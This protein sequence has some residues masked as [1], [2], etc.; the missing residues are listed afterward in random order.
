MPKSTVREE[1]AYPL[2][3]DILLPARLDKVTEVER[4]FTYQPH[5]KAVQN[6]RAKVGETASFVKWS[7]EFKITDGEFAGIVAYGDTDAKV[8][9]L[10]GDP[11]RQWA[12]TLLGRELSV[13][14][15]LDTDLLLGLPCKITV[16][17]DE[18]RP[19]R[20]GSGNFY[21]CPVRDVYPAEDADFVPF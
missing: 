17:H 19:R 10:D 6:G 16:T 13:G 11:V 20:D 2:P 14:E 12:E 21:P 4:S 15:E 1:T 9:N 3:A 7:W 5:H 18:P 8:T